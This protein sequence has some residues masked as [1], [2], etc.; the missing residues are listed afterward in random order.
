MTFYGIEH[1]E[2]SGK[3]LILYCVL[4]ATIATA[5]VYVAYRGSGERVVNVCLLCISS[6]VALYLGEALLVYLEPRRTLVEAVLAGAPYD[7][8]TRVEVVL[9]LRERGVSAEPDLYPS[10][11]ATLN[12]ASGDRPL[13]PLSGISR[14]L[15]VD[16]NETG[17]FSTF[18]SDEHGFRNPE[19][20]YVPGQV[21]LALVGD[22]F[23]HGSCVQPG[24]ELA[25][26][27]RDEFPKTLSF[28][29]GGNGPLSI[30][31]SI[32]EYVAPLRPETVLWLHYDGNDLYNLE[33]ELQQPFLL[34]YRA[35]EYRQ[36]LI[37]RQS[38]IDSVLRKVSSTDALR[39]GQ[40]RELL[41]QFLKGLKLFQ[42]RKRFSLRTESRDRIAEQTL[43]TFQSILAQ[44]QREIDTS[45]GRLF[46]VYLPH[47]DKFNGVP[48][49]YRREELLR[50]V[51]ELKLPLIDVEA[52]FRKYPD[53]AT[54]YPFRRGGHFTPAG[55]ELVANIV[56]QK[57][58][59]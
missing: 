39:Q 35:P 53:P 1:A 23:A 38:E 27:L 34:R 17:E 31:A 22:S 6:L 36:G 26:Q 40:R 5:L 54:F 50:I 42:L 12:L 3:Y 33:A 58:K 46:F 48:R 37:E 16:C 52:E 19:D 32:R 45:G 8:R 43:A 49:D 24:E 2:A 7:H 21:E 25:A 59:N 57:L 4:P 14:S 11:L 18:Q 44:A 56:L 30:L 28:G 41:Q 51:D 15:T 9:D 55:Y 10:Y 29:S 47:R 13:Y 20:L